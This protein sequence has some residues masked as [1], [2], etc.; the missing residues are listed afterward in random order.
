[1]KEIASGS[2]P[3]GGCSALL[4]NGVII[5]AAVVDSGLSLTYSSSLGQGSLAWFL[6]PTSIMQNKFD[7]ASEMGASYLIQLQQITL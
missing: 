7:E 6:L 5:N 1:M 4:C 3:E 2:G